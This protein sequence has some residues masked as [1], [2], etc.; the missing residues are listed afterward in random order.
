MPPQSSAIS[1]AASSMPPSSPV[2]TSSTAI[3]GNSSA[4][5]SSMPTSGRTSS[6]GRAITCPVRRCAGTCSA[7]PSAARCSKTSYSFS[8]IIKAS[9]SITLP[10]ATSS[11]SSPM[12]ERNGDFSQLS[13]QLKDPITGAPYLGNQIPLSQLDPVAQALFASKFYPTPIN[14]I[15]RTTPSTRS[16]IVEH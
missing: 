6:T 4:T 12:Q 3:S 8:P 7:A 9:V 15:P 11:R 2:P 1:P 10:P 14:A 16:I 5:I 13:K